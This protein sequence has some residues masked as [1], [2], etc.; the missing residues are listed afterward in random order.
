MN[1]SSLFRSYEILKGLYSVYL[2]LITIGVFIMKNLFASYLKDLDFA[3]LV[4]LWNTFCHESDNGTL[5]DLIYENVEELIEAYDF[6]GVETARR[7]HAGNVTSLY[8]FAYL[9][10]YA[11]IANAISCE[12]SPIDVDYLA[13]WLEESEHK[14]WLDFVEAIEEDQE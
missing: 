5:D 7:L 11:N 8:A 2:T 12:L 3:Y 14:E 6:S 1:R 9:N 13:D 10:G 4:E